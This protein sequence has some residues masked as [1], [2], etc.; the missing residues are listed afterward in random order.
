[1]LIPKICRVNF[2][3]FKMVKDKAI[4]SQI[5]IIHLLLVNNLKNE[6][7]TL[8]QSFIVGYLIKK[9]PNS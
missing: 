9:L 7:I 3:D 5:H 6:Q 1:M 2:L 4:T 8:L